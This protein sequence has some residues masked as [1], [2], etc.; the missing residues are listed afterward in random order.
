MLQ[1]ITWFHIIR[2]GVNLRLVGGMVL[3]RHISDS[4]MAD[5]TKPYNQPYCRCT[6]ALNVKAHILISE[7]P[8]CQNQFRIKISYQ[9]QTKQHIAKL[10][11]GKWYTTS[12]ATAH[13]PYELILD[14]VFIV[15]IITM[16]KGVC[17]DQSMLIINS[18]NWRIQEL[19]VGI[20]HKLQTCRR[21]MSKVFGFEE[22]KN[23]DASLSCSPKK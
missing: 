14:D 21:H 9:K 18:L 16:V 8:Y 10:T 5:H 17:R 22:K 13:H 12:S 23:F 4:F 1:I 11:G 6:I 15:I 7:I 2:R 20:S 3:T 19:K